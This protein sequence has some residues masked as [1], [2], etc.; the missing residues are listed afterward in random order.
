[1]GSLKVSLAHVRIQPSR[2]WATLRLRSA[3]TRAQWWAR[4][5]SKPPVRPLRAPV[6]GLR[7]VNRRANSGRL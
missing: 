7:N 2:S 6:L 3:L 1:M 5:T 4:R